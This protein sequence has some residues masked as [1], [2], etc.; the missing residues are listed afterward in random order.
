MKKLPIRMVPPIAEHLDHLA[1]EPVVLTVNGRAV[2]AVVALP[3]ADAET[4][5]LSTNPEFL[6]IIERSRQRHEREGGISANE[7]R[8]R[9]GLRPQVEH[10]QRRRRKATPR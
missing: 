10:R 4:I 3:N 9:L 6:D 1:E 8:R 7:M 2:A 5:S